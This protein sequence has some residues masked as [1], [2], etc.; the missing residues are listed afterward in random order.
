MFGKKKVQLEFEDPTASLDE[1]LKNAGL[2]DKELAIA[3]ADRHLIEAALSADRIIISR[4]NDARDAF[5]KA[6]ESVAEIRDITWVNPEEESDPRKWLEAGGPADS[7]R[8]L[9]A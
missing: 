5:R 7:H 1:P 8:L 9:E 6:A 2:N 3:L 4:D